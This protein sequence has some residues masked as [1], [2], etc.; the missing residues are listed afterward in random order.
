MDLEEVAND[1]FVHVVTDRVTDLP[2]VLVELS[3]IPVGWVR[4]EREET[5]NKPS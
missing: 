2:H 5:V 4:V 3:G 1:G